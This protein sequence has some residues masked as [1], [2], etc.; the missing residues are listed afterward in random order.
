MEDAVR[1]GTGD[2]AADAGRVDKWSRRRSH[3]VRLEVSGQNLFPEAGEFKRLT[4]V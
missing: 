3:H 2:G 1:K 4:K